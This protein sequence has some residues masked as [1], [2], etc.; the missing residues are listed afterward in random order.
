[1]LDHHIVERRIAPFRSNSVTVRQHQ[2]HHHDSITQFPRAIIGRSFGPFTRCVSQSQLERQ[3]SIVVA[4]TD[5][6][7]NV[8]P[9]GGEFG[10]NDKLHLVTSTQNSIDCGTG[11]GG[12][13]TTSHTAPTPIIGGC[14]GENVAKTEEINGRIKA[15]FNNRTTKTKTPAA[16]DYKFLRR[17]F[18]MDQRQN[19]FAGCRW[20]GARLESVDLIRSSGQAVILKAPLEE[21]EIISQKSPLEDPTPSDNW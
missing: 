16:A 20:R 6:I 15:A 4:E 18:S 13:D 7:L 8:N 17:Q 14:G 3:K 9:G 5:I 10:G 1:M 2:L 21:E 19:S 11:G 12:A